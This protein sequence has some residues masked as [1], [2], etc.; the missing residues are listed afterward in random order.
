[1]LTARKSLKQHFKQDHAI[2]KGAVKNLIKLY[3]QETKFSLKRHLEQLRLQSLA[4][5]QLKDLIDLIEQSLEA[6][7]ENAGRR[8]MDDKVTILADSISVASQWITTYLRV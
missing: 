7:N 4:R 6:I 3:R 1:M 2:A 5:E 8:E